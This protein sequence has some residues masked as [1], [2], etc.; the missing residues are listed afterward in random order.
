MPSIRG[1][2]A[3]VAILFAASLLLPAA[4]SADELSGGPMACDPLFD[5]CPGRRGTAARLSRSLGT[6]QPRG[7]SFQRRRRHLPAGSADAGIRI[8]AGAAEAQRATLLREHERARHLPERHAAARVGGCR[9]HHA[10][11]RGEHYDRPGR[12]LRSGPGT[13]P[14]AAPLRFWPDP[15][16]GGATERP[17]LDPSTAR[18]DQRARRLRPD[19][20]C[21]GQPARL[22]ARAA[23]HSLPRV[24]RKLRPSR[25]AKRCSSR[26]KPSR[27]RPSTGMRRCGARTT[28]T[29]WPRSGVGGRIGVGWPRS[30]DARRGAKG[31][32]YWMAP[33]AVFC[34]LSS[35]VAISF[36]K[37][38]RF[39]TVE[40]SERRS[41]SSLTVPFM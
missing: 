30:P 34:V 41:A 40:Y 9:R 16:A 4:V 22:S 11:L 24:R 37:P 13:G 28:R 19:R 33:A 36:S 27:N 10:A 1:L 35:T 32:L 17:L 2:Q 38:S 26:W 31:V 8:F 6:G 25:C 5:E 29:A 3:T 23:Q 15:R 18:T 20:R 12:D 14:G 21:G 7:A 39:K